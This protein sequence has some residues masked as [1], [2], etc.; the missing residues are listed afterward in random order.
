MSDR[1]ALLAAIRAR[2][3]ED[4][5]RLMFADWLDEHGTGTEREWAA[6]IRDDVTHAARDPFDPARLRWELIVKPRREVEAWARELFAGQSGTAPE[7]LLRRG[8]PWLVSVTAEGFARLEPAWFARVPDPVPWFDQ[9]S[10]ALARA[11]DA[12]HFARAAG[13][14]LLGTRLAAHQALALG[15]SRC[16]AALRAIDS[17]GDGIQGP[18][19]PVLARSDLFPRLE[20]F[21]VIEPHWGGDA[22]AGALAELPPVALRELHFG[23]QQLAAERV[24]ELLAS[25]VAQGLR[26]LSFALCALHA[27]GVV[28]LAAAQL[29]NLE[30][31]NAMNTQCGSHGL[32]ALAVSPL[33]AQLRKLVVT[34]NRINATAVEALAARPEAAYLR[35]LEIGSNSIG[36]AGAAAL[37]RSPHLMGLLALDLSFCMVG[38]EGIEA[39][40]E[41][42]L[43]DSLVLLRMQGAPASAEAKAALA[44]R[45]GDRVRL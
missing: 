6:F 7:A 13:L 10:L 21:A 19:L 16:T 30:V 35:V 37:F 26:E 14:K 20:R 23:M 25:P 34:N 5:P 43:C 44:A 18:A 9:P 28:R 40:L 32:L 12:P 29:P 17:D 27:D 45:M 36:N 22:F 3:A 24:T 4:V 39:L 2:P 42:P 31:L 8:F 33:L 1:D 41:S 15:N 11:F 38:D